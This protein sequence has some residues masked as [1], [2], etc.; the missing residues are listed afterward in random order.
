MS[1][2][3]VSNGITKLSGSRPLTNVRIA[4][5]NTIIVMAGNIIKKQR[6]GIENAVNVPSLMNAVR[7]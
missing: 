7:L 2:K 6:S 1:V 5:E 4:I 3:A